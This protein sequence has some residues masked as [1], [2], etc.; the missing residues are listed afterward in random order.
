MLISCKRIRS[1]KRE[2]EETR[3]G[4]K[5]A[6]VLC[7]HPLTHD[8]LSTLVMSYVW[9]M[10]DTYRNTHKWL[11]STASD[12]QLR[13][14]DNLRGY[15]LLGPSNAVCLHRQRSVL[16]AQIMSCEEPCPNVLNS[17]NVMEPRRREEF[18][19]EI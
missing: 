7:K 16:K 4:M 3:T 9:Y 17:T 5:V 13:F 18:D 14:H 2:P 15:T 12:K 1:H 11:R 8:S 6:P 19:Q 10:Y